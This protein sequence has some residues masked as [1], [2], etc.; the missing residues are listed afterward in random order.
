MHIGLSLREQFAVMS[1]ESNGFSRGGMPPFV[2]P[3]LHA[4]NRMQARETLRPTQLTERARVLLQ[5]YL[6]HSPRPI[7]AAFAHG[8]L[9]LM[10]EHTHFFNGFALMMP[11]AHGTAVAVRQAEGRVSRVIFE[12]EHEPHIFHPYL[13][14]ADPQVAPA[15][16][17]DVLEEIVGTLCEEGR[18]VEVAVVTTVYPACYEARVAAMSIAVA[19]A[20][21]ALLAHAYSTTEL[22]KIIHQCVVKAAQRPFSIAYLIAADAG[23][24]HTLLLVDTEKVEHIALEAPSHESVGWGMMDIHAAVPQSTAFFIQRAAETKE[25][26]VLLQNSV[27]PQLQSF[28]DLDHANL[29]MALEALPPA[30]QSRVRYLVGENKRVQRLTFAIRHRDWQMLGALLLISKAAQQN[31]WEAMF[32]EEQVAIEEVEQMSTEGMYGATRT[33]SGGCVLMV[34]QPFT[35]PQA[36]DRAKTAVAKRFSK[37]PEIVLL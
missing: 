26:L 10:S 5:D 6:G 33:G 27:F 20:L 23:R 7:E 17:R 13:K 28:R 12:G 9:G 4:L 25:A 32:E 29:P 16:L 36:L 2:Q 18:A 31:D 1:V 30:L 21:Q 24:P 35:V 3:F 19:R 34:G 37:V 14:K 11:L 22:L 8:C 15:V